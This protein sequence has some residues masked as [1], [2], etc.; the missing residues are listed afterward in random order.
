[1]QFLAGAPSRVQAR[2][3]PRDDSLPAVQQLS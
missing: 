2:V 1:M 3:E